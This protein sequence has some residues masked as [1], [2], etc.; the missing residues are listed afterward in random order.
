MK[1]LAFVCAAVFMS[2]FSKALC[3]EFKDAEAL[4]SVDFPSGWEEGQSKDPSVTLRLET[5]KSFFE[6]A[7]LDSELSDY[8]LQARLK[9]QVASIR[10]KGT[11]LAGDIRPLSLHGVSSA[12]YISYESMGDHC[13]VAFFTYNGASYAISASGLD[14]GG[15]RAIVATL[16]K[17]G[18]KISL[19]KPKKTRMV[20][21]KKP[22]EEEAGEQ[23]FMEDVQPV[24]MEPVVR[25]TEAEKE[26]VST[27]IRKPAVSREKPAL[28][29]KAGVFL[30]AL[31]AKRGGG[32]AAPYLDRKPLSMPVWGAIILLWLAGSFIARVK[33]YAYKNPKLP[34]PPKDVPPDFFFPFLISR[35]ATLKDV[36]Y[37]ITNRQKQQMQAW[38]PC[39]YEIYFA[40]AV[41]GALLFNF[42]WRLLAFSGYDGLVTN[43]LL[44]LP[45]GRFFASFPEAFFLVFLVIG[46]GKY[47]GGKKILRLFDAQSN[48]VLQVDKGASYGLI[49][50]KEGKEVAR[51]VAKHGVTGRM[52]EYVDSN[53]T[54][55]FSIRDDCP[56]IRFMRKIFGHLGG[57]LRTR[58]GI[59]AQEERAGYVF[60]DPFSS[61]RFQIHLDF[62]FA[63]LA[64]PAHI[65]AVFLYIISREKD[66]VYPSPF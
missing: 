64:H 25:A 23:I 36:S 20:K 52:W 48:L 60:L 18:E 43:F 45:G 63:R 31:A 12:Y 55:I 37:N 59:F 51:L 47:I 15:F 40:A 56:R 28:A 11:A 54:V 7:K 5:G 39:E 16:R 34:L 50:D 35:A 49:R 32:V 42:I 10:S 29:A 1:K 6:F 33:A 66:P 62:A 26:V 27:F 3:G 17:P 65:L 30:S 21:S 58:Y 22:A 4:F 44:A 53:K 19:P 57:T 14:E 9:E 41:Y 61:D 24:P 13:Y 38:F 46:I 2:L 8:Y